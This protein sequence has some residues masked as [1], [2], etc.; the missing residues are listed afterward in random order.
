MKNKIKNPR[1]V[2][3]K[4]RRRIA[5]IQQKQLE[6]EKK[7]QRILI[8]IFEEKFEKHL[9]KSNKYVTFEVSEQKQFFK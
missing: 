2:I 6:F 7:V 8:K 3:E 9:A 4:G 1:T 5:E